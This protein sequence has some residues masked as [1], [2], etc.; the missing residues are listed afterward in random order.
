[1]HVLGRGVAGVGHPADKVLGVLP[2][3]GCVLGTEAAVAQELAV[4]EAR[5]EVG[6]EVDERAAHDRLHAV[7]GL[8]RHAAEVARADEE[9][10]RGRARLLDVLQVVAG[11]LL[12]RF[13][14]A[15]ALELAGPAL[16]ALD[17][18]HGVEHALGA[19]HAGHVGEA[20]GADAV[21]AGVGQVA[22][23]GAHHLPVAH[24]HVQKAVAGAAAAADAGK[25]LVLRGGGG[26]LR[27]GGAFGRECRGGTGGCEGPDRHAG[28]RPLDERPAVEAGPR[29]GCGLLGRTAGEL[30]VC[31]VSP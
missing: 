4:G 11:D 6:R 1:M 8:E 22:G 16:A 10:V 9:G 15:D 17:A 23:R 13:V 28:R 24:V 2:V 25:D 7:G 27:W 20:L 29:S 3:G 18:A 21:V 26:P 14:P 30:L 5:L 12:G 31:H 19:V